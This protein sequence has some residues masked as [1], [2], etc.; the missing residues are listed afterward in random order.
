[1]IAAVG[2]IPPGHKALF[3]AF[4][5]DVFS[6]SA[7]RFVPLLVPPKQGEPPFELQQQLQAL[8]LMEVCAD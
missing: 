7:A 4:A 8:P 2:P 5:K 1:M 3:R 6:P